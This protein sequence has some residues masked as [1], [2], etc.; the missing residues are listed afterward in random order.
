MLQFEISRDQEIG[1]LL[2]AEAA[3][4]EN[5]RAT[6]DAK[7]APPFRARGGIGMIAAAIHTIRDDGE[8]LCGQLPVSTMISQTILRDRREAGRCREAPPPDSF[9][10]AVKRRVAPRFEMII[11]AQ[12]GGTEACMAGEPGDF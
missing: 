12:H 4:I 7:P 9:A 3:D 1:T 2:R 6:V 8:L 5:D 10:E 11:A